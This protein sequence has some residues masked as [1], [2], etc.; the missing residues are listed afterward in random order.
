MTEQ[1]TS[2]LSQLSRSGK[3]KKGEDTAKYKSDKKIKGQ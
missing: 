3:T 2:Q 1:Y